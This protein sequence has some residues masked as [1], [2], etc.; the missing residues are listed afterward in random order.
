MQRQDVCYGQGMV[1]HPAI[2]WQMS[3][4]LGMNHAT[5]G[6]NVTSMVMGVNILE[7]FFILDQVHHATTV[8]QQ[9]F[10]QV[11]SFMFLIECLS[12]MA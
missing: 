2:P 1:P 4:H 5:I 8:K 9:H 7:H 6:T 11:L 10:C 12:L 3:H